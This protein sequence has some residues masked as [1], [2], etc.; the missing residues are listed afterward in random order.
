MS[1]IKDLARQANILVNESSDQRMTLE[2]LDDL[3]D[4]KFAELI[5][6]ECIELYNHD[7]LLASVGQSVWGEAY[8]EGWIAG[9]SSY[10]DVISSHFGIE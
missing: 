8:Q 7:E 2:Q 6:K 1:K 3:K 4:E 9:V 5:I 10:K